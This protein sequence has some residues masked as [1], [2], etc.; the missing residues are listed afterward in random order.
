[1]SL[2]S[3]TATLDLQP[4]DLHNILVG[5]YLE[6]AERSRHRDPQK[7]TSMEHSDDIL[8]LTLLVKH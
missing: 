5:P 2:G 6:H 8:I 1:M 4:W 3:S 7:Q